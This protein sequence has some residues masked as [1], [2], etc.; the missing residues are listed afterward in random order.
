MLVQNYSDLTLDGMT[1]T[2]NN[3][4]YASAYTLSNNNGDVV[5]EDTTINVNPAGGF[6]FDVCRYSSYPSVNVTVKDGSVINGNIEV[7]ASGSNAMNGFSLMLESGTF[8]GAIVLDGTGA[9]AMAATPDKA[10]V[11]KSETVNIT[12]PED[13]K[14]VETETEGVVK[15][16]AKDYVAQIGETKYETL[17]EAV[18]AAQNGETVKLLADIDLADQVEITKSLTLDLNGKTISNTTDIWNTNMGAW[19]LISVQGAAVVTITGDGS[20]I[21]KAND[22]YALDVRDGAKLIVENGTYN[23]NLS[24]IYAYAG[25]VVINGGTFKLQQL[26]DYNDT[27]Y[28]LNCLDANY[29]TGTAGFS[30]TGGTFAG[31]DP[32]NNA[33]E[34][35]GT[36]FVAANHVA[37]RDGENY[38]VYPG[39]TV[40]FNTN[41]GTPAIEAQRVMANEQASCPEAPAKEEY[42]FLGWYLGEALYDFEASV[43]AD[44]TLTAKWEQNQYAFS[45]VWSDDNATVTATRT[46][47]NNSDIERITETVNTTSAVKTPATCEGVGEETYTATFT[48]AVFETQTKTVELPALGHDLVHHEAKAATCTEIGWN[49]YDT[50]SRCDYTTYVEIPALGHDLEHH[51]AKAA[52]CTEIGWNEYDTCSRCDYTTYVEIPALGHDLEHH[53]AKAATCTEIGWNEYDTCSRCDYTTYVEIPATGHDWGEP[54]YEWFQAEG[55][56]QCRAS[57]TCSNDDSHVDSAVVSYPGYQVVTAASCNSA[58]LGRYTATFSDPFETQTKDVTIPAIEHAWGNYEITPNADYSFATAVFTCGNCGSTVSVADIPLT[59]TNEGTDPTCTSDGTWYYSYSFNFNGITY[60]GSITRN[61]DAIG[62]EL[63]HHDAKAATCL[64]AGN[65]EYWTCDRCGG[66]FSD[67]DATNATT[68]E[69]VVIAALGHDFGAWT[70]TTAP[71]CTEAGEETRYCSRC[72]A[73]ETQPVNALGHNLEHHEAKAATCLAAGNSEYWTCDR[74]GGYFSDEDATNATT[75]EAVVIAALGH[76]FGAWT[77]TTAP[78]CTEAGEETRYCSRCDATETRPVEALGHNYVA[79]VTAPTCTEAGYTTHTCSRCGDS[80]TD[81][82]VNALGHDFGEWTQTTAPTCTEAGVETR[83]CSRCDATETRP[84]EA[85]GHDY[86]AVVTA[87]TCTE[88]GYTTHTCSRCNDS[89]VDTYVDALGHNF[90][91]WTVTTAATCTTAGIETRVCANDA[92]HTET[93]EIPATGHNWSTTPTWTWEDNNSAKATLT[94]A[95]DASHKN[96]VVATVSFADGTGENAGYTVYTATATVDEQTY[97]DTRRVPNQYTIFY[98]LDGGTLET[99][100]PESY[101][102]ESETITL[103]NPTRAHYTFKGWSGTG[104]TGD[105]NTTVTIPTGSTGDRTYT[106][107]WTAKEEFYLVGI[108]GG[109]NYW[110]SFEDAFLF[111]KN[112]EETEHTE[113]TLDVTL[114]EGDLLKVRRLYGDNDADWYWYPG[115]DNNNYGINASMAGDVTVYFR[116]NGDGNSDWHWGVIWI[117]KAHSITMVT[118]PANVGSF[119]VRMNNDQGDEVTTSTQGTTLYVDV[120]VPDGYAISAI[121]WFDTNAQTPTMNDIATSGNDAFKFTMPDCDVTVKVTYASTD[122]PVTLHVYGGRLTTGTG[123]YETPALTLDDTNASDD[124]YTGTFT[125]GTAYDLPTAAQITKTGYA[126][127]G[128]YTDEQCTDGNEATAI[129]ATASEAQTFWAKWTQLN[130]F[131]HS[132]NFANV[133]SYLYRVGNSNTVK[134]GSLFAVAARRDGE[135]AAPVS[136]N[137]KIKIT[138]EEAN[139]TV[140]GTVANSNLETG[141]TAKCVYTRNSSDWM[142]STLKFTGEGPVKVTIKEGDTGAEYTLNLEVVNGNNATTASEMSGSCVLLQNITLPQDGTKQF[143]SS[144]IYG[145]GFTFDITQGSNHAE[146]RGIIVLNSC[147]LDNIKI[148]GAVYSSYSANTGANYAYSSSAVHTYGNTLIYNSYISNC[149]APLRMAS[150]TLT[151]KNSIIDGGR[152]CNIDVQT[153]TLILD[154]ATTINEP[155]DGVAGLGVVITDGAGSADVIIRNGLHQYNWLAQNADASAFPSDLR[156]YF[157]MMYNSSL[158]SIQ[159][160]YNGDTYVNAGILSLSSTVGV[161]SYHNLPSSYTTA[162]YSGRA[163]ASYGKNNYTLSASDLVYRN[164]PINYEYNEQGIIQPKYTWSYPNTDNAYYD[165]ELNQLIVTFVQGESYTLNTNIL[166]AKK[167]GI[168]LPVTAKLNNNT[169]SQYTFTENGDYDF[170]YYIVDDY[171]YDES[172]AAFTYT[173]EQH[174]AVHVTVSVPSIPAPVFTFKSPNGTVTTNTRQ[175]KVGTENYIM[176]DVSATSNKVIGSVKVNNNTIYCPI[177]NT[178]F[179]DNSSDFNVIYSIFE[180]VT[181]QNYTS[182]TAS[183][184]YSTSTNTTSLPTGLTWIDVFASDGTSGQ[185]GSATGG[186]GWG[187]YARDRTYGLYRSSN[188]IGS[189]KGEMTYYVKYS[190]QAGDG[191]IYYYFIGYYHASHKCPSTCFAEGTMIT[192]ADGSQKAIENIQTSD[193]IMSFNHATGMFEGRPIAALVNHGEGVYDVLVLSFSDSTQLRIIEDHGLFDLTLRKYININQRNYGSFIGHEFAKYSGE[194]SIVDHVTLLSAEVVTEQTSSWSIWSHENMN[195]VIDNMLGVTTGINGEF[196]DGYNLFDFDEELKYDTVKMY[197][198]IQTYGLYT[199]D[200]WSD[201]LDYD[202]FEKFNI[203]FFKVAVGK[204]YLTKNMIIEYI[205]WYYHFAETG[206]LI[207]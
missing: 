2:L 121:Q 47:T 66:Y 86:N 30:I 165:S 99:A 160:S 87:P 36:N 35:T 80:Y 145:N 18:E 203:Q 16:V 82:P 149:R 170:V 204:G 123:A 19:S 40:T 25:Q 89:Y 184:T 142:Q 43:T 7:Y 49:E 173:H 61:M 188:A 176:P 135:I 103:T 33:A 64:A 125:P 144:T 96:E 152:Y 104:L 41:G 98:N 57:R 206:E 133:D 73:T 58:G 180:G 100:N 139:S 85:L 97:T 140:K 26:S 202:S 67:E 51:E 201:Y 108:I 164:D 105:E 109:Q 124:L 197:Q 163:I 198:D 69:A 59:K 5:I 113:Y 169:C 150:G 68:A 134:L 178:R 196:V 126:F 38:T 56:W 182:A 183:T 60:S 172:G 91:E 136:A 78:T 151:V 187:G 162:T 94:C 70:Q 81:T 185:S 23:G 21:A 174:L 143:A 88:A 37:I 14:W 65:S 27:R 119:T 84:V 122:C 193:W 115:G 24:T 137:V 28:M 128:W 53:E 205:N 22:C 107:N 6:A 50:C 138:A 71:T 130:T 76:D 95:N 129:L 17:A 44:I 52:T 9:A 175:L 147:T 31:F 177:V 32:Q 12:I 4:N 10:T 171:C 195:H 207:Q 42:K 72:D 48:N 146:A 161:E 83:E 189:D 110:S 111:T 192:L 101:T 39:G 63:I 8:N 194:T 156:S 15:L 92:S 153:G 131:I 199:Y 191:N 190:Y 45:Y 157:N 34:G 3:A 106:A 20:M 167:F 46:C 200:E 116:P 120:T 79:V 74:C 168:S 55:R 29:T 132:D 13:Y 186:K 54:T 141:S 159:F 148:V 117:S 90:G 11:K 179:K 127:G 1:L 114:S 75:A 155:K 93:R 112:E 62:H 181:I 77:Q 118:D 154:N 158:S 102:V 166:T